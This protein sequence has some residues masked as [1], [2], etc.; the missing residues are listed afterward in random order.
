M[1]FNLKKEPSIV[2][3]M[4]KSMEKEDRAKVKIDLV[5]LWI[6]IK[7]RMLIPYVLR[8]KVYLQ[9][10][11]NGETIMICDLEE[12]EERYGWRGERR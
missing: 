9:D 11:E 3:R 8:N 7:E 1:N 10:A 2:R 12:V 6:L 5:D 4:V